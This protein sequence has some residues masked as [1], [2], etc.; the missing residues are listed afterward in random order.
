M[1]RLG[2]QLLAGAA[3]S[4]DQHRGGGRC[5]LA[6][7]GDHGV[8]RQRVADDTL[9]TE[10][11]VELLLIL[12]IRPRQ[13]LRPGRLVNHRA[14][15]ADIQRFGQVGGRAGLHGRDS[16]LDCAV[17]GEDHHLGVRQLVFRLAQ[18]LQ[19]ADPFHDQVGDD[20][21]EGLFLDQPQA[22]APLV[23]TTHS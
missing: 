4:G 23:A 7:P 18:D 3:F 5:D 6:Q 20:D 11:L 16:R 22:L 13:P 9:E 15:L 2:N 14:Q 8:H 21:I 10:L 17:S 19:A 1:Q 12:N